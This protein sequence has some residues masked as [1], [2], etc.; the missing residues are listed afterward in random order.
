[1]GPGFMR[2]GSCE[3]CA[4]GGSPQG[5]RS[6]HPWRGRA[7]WQQDWHRFLG[8]RPAARVV[9]ETDLQAFLAMCLQ[10]KAD[11]M[12]EVVPCPLFLGPQSLFL[13]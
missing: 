1:M 7:L 6:E 4:L 2:T 3:D 9:Q 8:M 5:G 11:D 10:L 13:Q 12:W